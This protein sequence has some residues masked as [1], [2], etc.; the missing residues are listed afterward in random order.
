MTRMKSEFVD[1]AKDKL[2]STSVDLKNVD[3]DPGDENQV[4][5]VTP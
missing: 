5:I 1:S 2:T 3:L 4:C